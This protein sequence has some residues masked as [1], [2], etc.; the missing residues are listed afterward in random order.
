MIHTIAMSLLVLLGLASAVLV[1]FMVIRKRLLPSPAIQPGLPP[2]GAQPWKRVRSGSLNSTTEAQ[3]DWNNWLSKVG[4]AGAPPQTRTQAPGSTPAMAP[5][6]GYNTANNNAY[7]PRATGPFPHNTYGPAPISPDAADLQN[8]NNPFSQPTVADRQVHPYMP[9]PSNTVLPQPAGAPPSNNAFSPSIASDRQTHS[10][11]PSPDN[12]GPSQVTTADQ[13]PA[14]AVFPA[15]DQQTVNDLLSAANID[16]IDPV[17]EQVKPSGRQ[18][19]RAVRL[20]NIKNSGPYRA[21]NKPTSPDHLKERI[22]EELPSLNGPF[23]TGKLNQY[24]QQDNV[25]P[26]SD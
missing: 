12:N 6:Q 17:T 10:D 3:G 4:Y 20:K 23:L 24:I 7:S 2:S 15:R 26:Q 19:T 25:P 18:V 9:P 8:N 14:R 16:N 21:V 5:N 11:M 1:S 13:R 22:S